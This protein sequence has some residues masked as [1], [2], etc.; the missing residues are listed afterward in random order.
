ML[1]RNNELMEKG[2]SITYEDIK[3]QRA[4]L[5]SKY[6]LRKANLQSNGIKL[7]KEYRDSLSLP[8]DV[9]RDSEGEDRGYISIGI[10]DDKGQFQEK[11]WPLLALDNDYKLKFKVATVVDDSPLTGGERH[12]VSISMWIIDGNL[13]V[14]VGSGQNEFIIPSPSEDNAFIEVC[15]AMKQL[16]MMSVT[17][18]RLD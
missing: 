6:R 7:I 17:D 4:N 15:T 10:F 16:L 14:D 2:M 9:W 5:E 11:V 12:V 3:K 18:S 8:N 1:I 13:H